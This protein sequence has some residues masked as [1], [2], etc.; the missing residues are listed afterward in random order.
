MGPP[1]AAR[2][3][4]RAV[5]ARRGPYEEDGARAPSRVWTDRPSSAPRPLPT[6]PRTSRQG[7]RRQ[8]EEARMAGTVLVV[9]DDH[10]IRMLMR[11]VLEDSGHAVVDVADGPSALPAARTT[12]PDVICL[13]IGLPGLDGFGVL[14]LLKDDPDLRDVPVLMVPAWNA[15]DYV[16]RALDGGAHGYVRKPFQTAE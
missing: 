5:G 8:I 3:R 6:P 4:S 13:D 1:R 14:G 16:A 12:R 9:E 10:M 15:P 7:C 11:A 2:P